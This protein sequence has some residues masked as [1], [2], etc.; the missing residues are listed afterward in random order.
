MGS[1]EKMIMRKD[2]DHREEHDYKEEEILKIGVKDIIYAFEDNPKV[3]EI[4]IKH[5][6]ETWL[7]YEI[8]EEN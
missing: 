7:A 4:Y 2:N 8:E 5:G 6:I 3:Q 1:I